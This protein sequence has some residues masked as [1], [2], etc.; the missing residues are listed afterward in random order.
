MFLGYVITKEPF[1]DRF[2]LH[3]FRCI[4]RF[5]HESKF[6]PI[7]QLII[8]TTLDYIFVEY[9]LWFGPY[10]VPWP[11]HSDDVVCGHFGHEATGHVI[12][13]AQSLID[14]APGNSHSRH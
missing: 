13:F 10:K 9:V 2:N 7:N 14:V 1:R 11:N 5:I 8:N 3:T 12:A 6:C 4:N